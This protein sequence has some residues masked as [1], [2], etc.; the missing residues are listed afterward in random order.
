MPDKATHL[1]S[2]SSPGAAAWLSAIPFF[3]FSLHLD[4]AE[5]QAPVKTW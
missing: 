1:P 4:P 3:E 5:F 2:V